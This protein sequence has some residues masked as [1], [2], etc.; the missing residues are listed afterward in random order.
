MSEQY[1]MRESAAILNISTG[2]M[3]LK[4]II[5]ANAENFMTQCHTVDRVMLVARHTTFL[6]FQ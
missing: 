5:N 4:I 3:W 1:R 2:V 6:R